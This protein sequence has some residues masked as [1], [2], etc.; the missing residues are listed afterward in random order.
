MGLDDIYYVLFRHKWKIIILAIAGIV[1]AAVIYRLKPPDYQSDAELFIKYVAEN[2][3]PG[4]NSGETRVPVTELTPESV[5]NSEIQVLSSFDVAKQAAADIG[6]EKILAKVG[7]GDDTNR[8]ANFIRSHLKAAPIP[9]TSVIQIEFKHPD[10]ELVQPVLGRIIDQ[11]LKKYEEIHMMAD[12][13][14]T[15]LSKTTDGLKASLEQTEDELRKAK[16]DAGVV[17][18]TDLAM[19]NNAEA[20]ELTRQDIRKAE[21]ELAGLQATYDEIIKFSSKKSETA[22]SVT[23]KTVEVKPEPVVAPVPDSVREDYNGIIKRIA[24]L[25]TDNANLLRDFSPESVRVKEN[26]N[27]IEKVEGDKADLI[28]K[29]PGLAVESP[30]TVQTGISGPVVLQETR[31]QPD[32][33]MNLFLT[34]MEIAGLT[35]KIAKLNDQLTEMTKTEGRIA[36]AA[37]H[38]QQLELKK[39]VDETKLK[40]YENNLEDLKIREGLGSGTVLNIDKF[41]TPSP[42]ARDWTKRYKAME[43]LIAGGFFAGIGWAFLIEFYLDA[44][45]RRPKEIRTKLGMRLFLSIPDVGKNGGRQT[46]LAGG[47]PTLELEDE[48]SVGSKTNGSTH[49]SDRLEIAPW[50]RSHSLHKHYEALRDRLL[51]YFEAKNLTHNPKLVALAGCSKGSGATTL[52]MGLAASLS[53]T[54][55]G[56]VLLVD[57]NQE[58]GAAQ[59]F[60]MGK[61]HCGLDEVLEN[62]NRDHAL[63]QENLYVVSANSNG[64]KLPRILPKRFASLLPKL[65][66]SDYDYII[67]DMP[68]VSETSVTLRLAGFMD[69]MLL[70][71]ESEKTNRNAVSDAVS[72]LAEAKANASIVLNKTRSY[73][74]TRLGQGI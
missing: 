44:S 35:S 45:I 29:Y 33:A 26:R 54:G 49:A 12:K 13:V 39:E 7:G 74:P 4:P 8:A 48:K 24:D 10:P 16:S 14:S 18:P 32:P 3:S 36:A 58:Q 51:G 22:A 47:R 57:M 11:Y 2:A 31:Q 21:A 52:A 67:F 66:A 41:Q 53:E 69:T 9:R 43:M 64:D 37:P 34:R 55:D 5:I 40:F 59:H 30:Q 63:V 60:Y 72:L 65:K 19:K 38:V 25:R 70:V 68:P 56:N 23:N 61:P 28:S 1:G 71:V 27:E 42:P 20:I 15:F 6:P 17:L 62:G 50:D 46:A 73:I